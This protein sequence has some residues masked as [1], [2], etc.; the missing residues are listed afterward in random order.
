MTLPMGNSIFWRLTDETGEGPDVVSIVLASQA[1]QKINE[2]EI[3][4]DI[5]SAPVDSSPP[6][7]PVDIE[8]DNQDLDLFLTLVSNTFQPTRDEA[9]RQHIELDFTDDSVVTIMHIVAA[10]HFATPYP[11][12]N[13]VN[14]E[15]TLSTLKGPSGVGDLVSLDTVDGYKSAVIVR[16]RNDEYIC[17]LLDDVQVSESFQLDRHDLL[18]VNKEWVLPAAFAE[19]CPGSDDVIH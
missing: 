19:N 8:W 6:E 9:D 1:Q 3:E 18:V 4:T 15:R 11:G 16:E 7:M 12:Q 17:V 13:L 14:V 5:I 10:A 2:M